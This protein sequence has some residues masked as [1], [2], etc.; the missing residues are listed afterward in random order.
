GAD[1]ALL[2]LDEEETLRA[3]P[4]LVEAVPARSLLLDVL[5]VKTP[6]VG[7]MREARADV[8]LLSIHPM[9]APALGFEGQNVAVVEVRPGPR[10]A[11]F[12]ALLGRWGAP[13]TAL[14]AEEHGAG[15]AAAQAATPAAVLAFGMALG[16]LGYDRDRALAVA[17]PV[18]RVLLALLARLASAD[19][20][21]YW[22]IQRSNPGAA[23]AVGRLADSC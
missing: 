16:G 22:T 23:G 17:T 7:L 14:T 18:H 19:P 10:A 3:F 20:E 6:I 15:T 5:S 8:E 11:E 1:C 13:G 9:F 2:C 12:T 4:G 21:V